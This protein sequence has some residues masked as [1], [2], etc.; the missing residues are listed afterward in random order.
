MLF[1]VVLFTSK[2][3]CIEPIVKKTG[4]CNIMCFSCAINLYFIQMDDFIS[5]F[6]ANSSF[7]QIVTKVHKAE[8]TD[9]ISYVCMY[10]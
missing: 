7:T 6:F 10:I 2:S 4:S 1:Y 5:F 3:T 8:E 9:Q